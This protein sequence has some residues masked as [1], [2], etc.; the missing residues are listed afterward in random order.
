MNAKNRTDFFGAAVNGVSETARFEIAYPPY[1]VNLTN[2]AFAK[3][4]IPRL[5]KVNFN[6]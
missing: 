6:Y 2:A 3:N 1:D 5:K 4:I